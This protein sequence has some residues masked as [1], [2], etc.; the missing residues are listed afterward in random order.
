MTKIEFDRLMTACADDGFDAGISIRTE[1]EPLA[2]AGA[3]VKP[4][5][6]AGGLFQTGRRWWG[7]GEER[8]PVDII[9]I[10][11]EPSQANR[12]EAALETHREVLGLPEVSL[13]LSDLEP[14]PP[15]VPRRL[16]SFRFP[17]RNADA[18]LRD[19]QVDGVEF[20][21]TDIGRSIF[22]ATTQNADA[23]MEWFPQALLFGFWQSHLGKKGSQAKH[24]RAWVS[25]IIGIQP[26]ADDVRSLGLKGDP[27]N[28][29]VN[30]EKVVYDKNWHAVWDLE[31]SGRKVAG[32][33][34]EKKKLSDIGHGQVPVTGDDA[35][36]SGVSFRTVVQQ[37]TVSFAA[38]RRVHTSV[39]SAEARALLA[40]I[41]LVA[42]VGAFGRSFN[43][44]SGC[45]LRPV[46]PEWIWLGASGD[47]QLE[48]LGFDDAVLLVHEAA[49]TAAA[50]GLR[51]GSRWPSPLTVQPTKNL[52]DAIRKTFPEPWE[53]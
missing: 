34:L 14:L 28:L 38:L 21:K 27:L 8:T 13:D 39:A 52:H 18:Y 19:A 37:S 53:A 20:I 6:Y 49:E 35:S 5:V 33:N 50:A 42:H 15:H 10:D 22:D 16:S 11:N 25:E 31:S 1:L 41:G 48:P 9:T 30:E 51:T 29:T 17:H 47:T 40:A 12:L 44:R 4:A 43:L 32:A 46:N 45:D 7:S 24:A 2:G 3:K 36:L 23:L 26:A